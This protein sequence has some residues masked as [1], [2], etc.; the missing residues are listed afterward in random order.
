MSTTVALSSV[1]TVV[2]LWVLL[3][4]FEGLFYGLQGPCGEVMRV[5]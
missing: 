3:V 1:P 4:T 5:Y 2:V